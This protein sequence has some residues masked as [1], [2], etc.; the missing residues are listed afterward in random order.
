MKKNEV[1]AKIGNLVF[2]LF[3]KYN[4]LPQDI[5]NRRKRL[6]YRKINFAVLSIHFDVTVSLRS[7]RNVFNL[8]ADRFFKILDIFHCIFG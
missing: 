4:N 8:T 3:E 2:M 1:S 6:T 5:Y 7:Y